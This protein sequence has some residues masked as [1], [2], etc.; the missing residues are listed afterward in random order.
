MIYH[1]LSHSKPIKFAMFHSCLHSYPACRISQSTPFPMKVDSS[2]QGASCFSGWGCPSRTL[3]VT[4]KSQEGHGNQTSVAMAAITGHTGCEQCPLERYDAMEQ[5]GCFFNFFNGFPGEN[6]LVRLDW[7]VDTKS[8]E[9]LWSPAVL[10]RD[11]YPCSLYGRDINIA[12][13]PDTLQ[14]MR[15]KFWWPVS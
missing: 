6:G 9:N 13:L 3:P 4:I 15:Q 8:D 14:K 7:M 12:N 11:P 10:S 2:S 1:D 5:V